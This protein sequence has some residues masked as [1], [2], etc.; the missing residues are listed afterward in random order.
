MGR[1]DDRP[2]YLVSRS[3]T[4]RDPRAFNPRDLLA[5]IPDRLGSRYSFELGYV[6][7]DQFY[8]R[9]RSNAEREGGNV[10]YSD[11]K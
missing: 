10:D 9:G 11:A 8:I 6:H 3:S 2:I 1:S 5:G 4:S 7:R